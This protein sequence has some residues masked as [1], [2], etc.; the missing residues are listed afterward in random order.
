MVYIADTN[1]SHARGYRKAV[2]NLGCSQKKLYQIV[3][4]F[5]GVREEARAKGCAT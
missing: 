5:G 1:I 4:L 2:F 3:F